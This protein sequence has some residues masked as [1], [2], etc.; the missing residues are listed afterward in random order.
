[1]IIQNALEQSPGV[2]TALKTKLLKNVM[3]VISQARLV[4][5]WVMLAAL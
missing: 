4:N 3:L 5:L 1:M 2:V